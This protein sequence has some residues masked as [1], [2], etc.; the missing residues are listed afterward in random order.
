VRA[1]NSAYNYL[2]LKHLIYQQ[3]LL[4]LRRH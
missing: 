3:N 4:E 1:E 2:V